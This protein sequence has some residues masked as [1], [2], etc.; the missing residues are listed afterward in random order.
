MKLTLRLKNIS[1][2]VEEENENGHDALTPR[3]NPPPKK[4]LIKIL[5]INQ[6]RY[7]G[8]LT[9]INE[10]TVSRSHGSMEIP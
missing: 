7:N 3:R 9:L 4:K 1:E 5:L 8:L 2:A 6:S 10:N